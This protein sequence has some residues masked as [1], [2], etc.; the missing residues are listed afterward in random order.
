MQLRNYKDMRTNKSNTLIGITHLNLR[1]KYDGWIIY[2]YFQMLARGRKSVLIDRVP[3]Q[4]SQL[5]RK[6]HLSDLNKDS[7]IK[8]AQT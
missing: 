2:Y 8:W 6:K 1:D 5:S 4:I 3:R 7:I